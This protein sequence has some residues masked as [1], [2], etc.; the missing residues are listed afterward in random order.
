LFDFFKQGAHPALPILLEAKRHSDAKRYDIKNRY[1]RQNMRRDPDAWIVDSDDGKGI[2]GVTHLP[3]GFRLHMMKSVVDPDVLKYHN[4]MIQPNHTPKEASRASAVMNTHDIE[5]A[6]MLQRIKDLVT[7]FR[8]EPL[9]GEQI[10]A[11]ARR[12]GVVTHHPGASDQDLFGLESL[13]E[14]V[15]KFFRSLMHS[16]A[17]GQGHHTKWNAIKNKDGVH[18]DFT[19]RGGGGRARDVDF[20]ARSND[21]LKAVGDSKLKEYQAFPE[22][23]PQTERLSNA[24]KRLGVKANDPHAAMAA[25]KKEYGGR[26]ILK[27]DG[28]FATAGSALL[29]DKSSGDDLQRLFSEGMRNNQGRRFSGRPSNMVV[30]PRLDLIPLGRHHIAVNNLTEMLQQKQLGKIK[31]VFSSDPEKKMQAR[32][33]LSAAFGGKLPFKATGSVSGGGAQEWRAHVV[34]GKVV[35]FATVLRGS[36]MGSLPMVTPT[37]LRLERDLQR[38]LDGMDPSKLKGTF[39]MD[40]IKDRAGN[41]RVIETNPTGQGG[42][43]FSSVGPIQDAIAAAIQGRLP[44]YV[45]AQGGVMAAGAG[46]AGLGLHRAV[47]DRDSNAV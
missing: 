25:L 9:F 34:N 31:D 43:G 7:P 15:R 45:K 44:T 3:T 35:P 41:F 42:S 36:V 38:Q 20:I 24:L 1:I 33:M 21:A 29:T 8:A 12:N 4:A 2:V 11:R 5:K 16:S 40:V 47:G 10:A 22:L 18:V 27:P 14:P 17:D 23:I 26:F 39:G 28:G 13:G 30:Q 19:G 6:A 37:R 46:A 32:Q